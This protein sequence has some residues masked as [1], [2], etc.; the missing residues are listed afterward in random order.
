MV[1]CSSAGKT[2]ITDHS[3][4]MTTVRMLDKVRLNCSASTD[5]NELGNLWITWTKNGSRID[6][7]DPRI[8]QNDDH[9][10]TIRDV[11][12][13]LDNGL[14]TCNASNG[15]DFDLVNIQLTVRGKDGQS[16]AVVTCFINQRISDL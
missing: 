7:S 12:L 15:L 3:P 9:S 5:P 1:V 10:L 13:K 2:V 8:V 6:P 16:I 11:R 14:Y 4:I